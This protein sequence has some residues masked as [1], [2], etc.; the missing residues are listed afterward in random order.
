MPLQI[1]D[2]SMS[3][4]EQQR[5][6]LTSLSGRLSYIS[7]DVL[8]AL[9]SISAISIKGQ[10]RLNEPWQYQ[11][12]FTGKNKQILIVSILSQVTLLSY[13]LTPSLLKITQISS[14]NHIS[15]SRKFYRIITEF[16]LVPFSEDESRYQVKLK[17]QI[18]LFATNHLNTIT[19]ECPNYS[20]SLLKK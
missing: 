18:A 9:S 4:M 7:I 17:H 2:C 12:N 10:E 8:N 20:Y 19:I 14:Y 13:H 15:K 5:D 1:K 3:I 6:S 11:I 16:S